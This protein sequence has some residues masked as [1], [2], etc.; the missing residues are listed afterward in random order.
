V[1]LMRR[2]V[3]MLFV[4]A[5]GLAGCAPRDDASAGAVQL[6]PVDGRDLPGSDLDRIKVGDVAPDFS[7]VSLA[8]PVVTLSSFRD[9]K[10]VILV[11]YRGYW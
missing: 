9:K 3:L 4:A 1:T 7:V 11:F 8:G 6:G 5:V 2:L 10:N